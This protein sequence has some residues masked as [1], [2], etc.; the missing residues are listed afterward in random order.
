[1]NSKS[2]TQTDLTGSLRESGKASAVSNGHKLRTAIKLLYGVGDVGNAIVNS[3]VQFY[4]L[5]FYTDVGLIAPGLAGTALSVAN[6][7][8][9]VNDPLFGGFSGRTFSHVAAR[10]V[11]VI[12]GARQLAITIALLW[13]VPR[14]LSDGGT[15]VWMAVT[16]VLYDMAWTLTNV[17]YYA[18]TAPTTIASKSSATAA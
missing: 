16:S 17:P 8:D 1:M 18:L 7:W 11:Y 2:A 5:L 10:R 3:G 15:F 6:I 12:L 13:F 4:L 14:G 9:A